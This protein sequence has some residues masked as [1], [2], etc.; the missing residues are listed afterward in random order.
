[1]TRSLLLEDASTGLRKWM[2]HRDKQDPI[3]SCQLDPARFRKHPH[4]LIFAR[5]APG[6]RLWMRAATTC[7]LVSGRIS[8]FHVE[9]R[10]D[11]KTF[12]RVGR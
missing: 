12:G 10:P 11:R 9:T 2:S 6:R 1:M 4:E 5:G 8:C 3:K 7:A